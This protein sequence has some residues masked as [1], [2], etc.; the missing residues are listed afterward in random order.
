MIH[1]TSSSIKGHNH[2]F[3]DMKKD[4]ILIQLHIRF[5]ILFQWLCYVLHMPVW[6]D[7]PFSRYEKNWLSCWFS[8]LYGYIFFFQL[9]C[10]I[11]QYTRAC[12]I[13]QIRNKPICHVNSA[14]DTVICSITMII[15]HFPVRKHKYHSHHQDHALC[16][17][18]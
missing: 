1:A 5:G 10:Y 2:Y 4:I 13:F 14:T 12:I 16:Q 15:L 7:M 3:I 6:K 8:H 17:R 18:M 11:C 9:L